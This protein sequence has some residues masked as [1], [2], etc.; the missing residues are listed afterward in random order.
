MV[1]FQVVGI[2]FILDL[3]T[4]SGG[5]HARQN[6]CRE[7]CCGVSLTFD[8]LL[9]ARRTASTLQVRG[10]GCRL[11]ACHIIIALFSPCSYSFSVTV[12]SEDGWLR[13]YH[14]QRPIHSA[15]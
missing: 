8:R 11:L 4:K 7:I 12:S 13:S 3:S 6:I 2:D 1:L 9:V 14:R 5:D 10:R 15:T